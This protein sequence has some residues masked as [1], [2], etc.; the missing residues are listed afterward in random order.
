[1]SSSLTIFLVA[2][3]L[4][5]VAVLVLG[6]YRHPVLW[7]NGI[8]AHYLTAGCGFCMDFSLPG[9]PSSWQAPAYPFL[10]FAAW[11]A[12]GEGA[13]AHLIVSLI[14]AAA[15]ASMV[16]PV[17]R[18]TRRW[19][20]EPAAAWAMWLT[21]GMPLLVWYATRLHQAGLVMALQPWVLF[22][23]VRLGDRPSTGRGAL[24][25]LGSGAAA[26]FQ[27]ILLLLAVCFGTAHA[28]RAIVA[29]NWRLAWALG[30]AAVLA[31]VVLAPWTIRN[32][33]VHGRLIPIRD[34][35]GKE[36]WMGNNPNATGTSFAVGGDTEITFAHPPKAFVLKGHVPEAELMD[37]MRRE[38]VDYIRAEPTAFVRRT[39]QKVFWFW[40]AAP[41]DRVRH[42]QGGEA[43]EFRWLYLGSWGAFV[44]LAAFGAWTTRCIPRSYWL[45]LA[46]YVA[47]Y[48]A[49]Y[50]VT[51]VGQ[52]RYRGEME[53]VLIPLAAAGLSA[54]VSIGRPAIQRHSNR[55]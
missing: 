48:S 23:W 4:R 41:A 26:L 10:L 2:F 50:G 38:A 19:F 29:H 31:G 55:L 7:E 45:T 51:H 32:Y 11:S 40:T 42:T 39:A 22:W 30:V 14:Q 28:V 8:I 47:V 33:Q 20:S 37:A 52:A 1:M 46:L 18:L 12:F 5:I 6:H 3:A 27:P 9:E 34:S 17:G 44:M 36:L 13:R 53:F 15:L 21:A 16:F 43:I 49:L 54:L 24:A 35:F 25:G